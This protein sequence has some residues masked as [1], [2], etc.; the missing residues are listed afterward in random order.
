MDYKS[1][2]SDIFVNSRILPVKLLYF[3]SVASLLHDFDNQRTTP[4]ISNPFHRTEQ[5]NSY[6]T[7]SA[8][9]GKFHVKILRTNQQLFSFSRIGPKI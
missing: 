6:S 9:A 2:I 7:R 3:K 5:I 8:M 1:R 4:N